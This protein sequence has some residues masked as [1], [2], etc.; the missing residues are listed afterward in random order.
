MAD[1]LSDLS[2]SQVI[3]SK[4]SVWEPSLVVASA[5]SCCPNQQSDP[6]HRPSKV[7][8]TANSFM[9]AAADSPSL[10]FTT[11]FS[12]GE[13]EF[14]SIRRITFPDRILLSKC[15]SFPGLFAHSL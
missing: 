1:K 12:L 2:I 15:S 4:S 5:I 3:I 14:S 11:A 7:L 8:S 9:A 13:I 6:P 10:W